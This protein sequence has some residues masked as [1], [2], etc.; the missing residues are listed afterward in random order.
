MAAEFRRVQARDGT[1]RGA[2]VLFEGER[3][4]RLHRDGGRILSAAAAPALHL[5]RTHPRH[6]APDTRVRL[7]GQVALRLRPARPRAVS[8]RHGSGVLDGDR[9]QDRQAVRRCGPDA[10][11]GVRQHAHRARGARAEGGER[12]FR[13]AVVADG[14]K[15]GGIPQAV[16]LRSRRSALHRRLRRTP[17]AQRQPFAQV[18]TRPPFV[19]DA[20]GDARA[21]PRRIV[22]RI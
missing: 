13:R 21:G 8:S 15:V 5:G 2:Y 19:C 6:A 3:L 4:E 22:G 20:G 10:G 7:V 1:R 11:G 12:R 16:R 17:R 9:P 18:D 14:G